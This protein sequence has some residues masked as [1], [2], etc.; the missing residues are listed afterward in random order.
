M[1]KITVVMSHYEYKKFLAYKETDK[2]QSRFQRSKKVRESNLK[3]K[4]AYY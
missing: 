3:L 1:D 4:S 2:I